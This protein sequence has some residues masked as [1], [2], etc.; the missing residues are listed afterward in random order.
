MIDIESSERC[1]G[2]YACVNACPKN[3]IKMIPDKEGFWYP[4]IDK[5]NCIDCGLCE[6][7]CPIIYKWQPDNSRTT[8]AMAAINMN[9][10][11]R[12][13]SSSGGIFTLIAEEIIKRGG[14]VFGAAFADDFRSVHHIY[15]DN[16][17]SLEKLRGSKYVQSKI[18]DTYKQAK[19]FLDSGRIVLFTGTPCQI[20]GLYSYLRKPYENL[21]TQDIICHG[22]PSPMVW[23][24]Y[25]DEREKKSASTT[26]RM[27]FRHK[28]YGWKTYAVL[29]EFSNN[30]AYVKNLLEDPYMRLFLSNVCLRPSCYSCSFKTE[31]RQ[32]DITL[33]DFWGVQYTVPKMDDDKGTSLVISHSEKGVH[34]MKSIS[35]FIVS[36][37]IDM[38]FVLKYN[39]A[40]IQSAKKNMQRE[41]VFERMASYDIDDIVND[42][43][44]IKLKS[45]VKSFLSKMGISNLLIKIK[46]IMIRGTKRN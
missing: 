6:K 13:K 20:G 24:K 42:L 29:F 12:L 32:A 31:S 3:C 41:L 2:C 5:E 11:I 44:P 26:Q 38:N 16:T 43:F 15:V 39:P 28:K 22:V 19:D 30:T 37:D 10:D 46:A 8:T 35:S 18:G 27:F 25:I 21:F 23:E 36:Q 34:L 14:V 33:A 4:Q 40:L 45:K 9:E 17:E 1:S 7:V